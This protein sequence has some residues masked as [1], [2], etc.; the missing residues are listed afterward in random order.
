M[1]LG[2]PSGAFPRSTRECGVVFF[3]TWRAAPRERAVIIDFASNRLNINVN[4][5]NMVNP[6]I[7][8]LVINDFALSG[9]GKAL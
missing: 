4:R 3:F 6:V 9:G 8:H 5:L 1:F 7:G 2:G